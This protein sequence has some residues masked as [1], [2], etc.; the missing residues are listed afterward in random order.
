[1]ESDQKIKRVTP[2]SML[3]LI[4]G[5]I[6]E[7]NKQTYPNIDKYILQFPSEV[8]EILSSLRKIIKELAPDAEDF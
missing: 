6:M 3:N 8:Q 2:F 7:E 4:K 1:L 5:D